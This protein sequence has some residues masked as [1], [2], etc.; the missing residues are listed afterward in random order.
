VE[1]VN[2]LAIPKRESSHI[3]F[4]LFFFKFDFDFD[5]DFDFTLTSPIDSV[6]VKLTFF[7]SSFLMNDTVTAP[8]TSTAPLCTASSFATMALSSVP[9]PS[10]QPLARKC[11]NSLFWRMTLSVIDCGSLD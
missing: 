11:R 4:V 5:F 3:L 6:V 1:F 2:S 9:I 10:I 7:I 8:Q